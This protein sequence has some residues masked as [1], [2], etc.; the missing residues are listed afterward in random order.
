MDRHTEM[1]VKPKT[2]QTTKATTKPK[3]TTT[4]LGQQK[5]GNGGAWGL[6]RW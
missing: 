6:D 4:K 2:K 3:T 5:V 1:G